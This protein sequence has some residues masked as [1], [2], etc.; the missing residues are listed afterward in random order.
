MQQL[1]RARLMKE[2]AEAA[3]RASEDA[4]ILEVSLRVWMV[5]A[6]L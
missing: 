3:R 1:Q 6:A 4:P 5:Q 2:E